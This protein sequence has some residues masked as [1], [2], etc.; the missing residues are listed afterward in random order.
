AGAFVAAD[1][2]APTDHASFASP[3]RQA[4]QGRAMALVRGAGQGGALNVT[5]TAPGLTPGKVVLKT[6]PDT[7]R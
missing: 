4:W 6:V 5:A 2:G 3:T 7:V 1:N